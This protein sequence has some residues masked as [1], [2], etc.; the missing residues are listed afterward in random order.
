MDRRGEMPLAEGES[1]VGNF[2]AR[3]NKLELV[4]AAAN[5]A[6]ER[7]GILD[8]NYRTT[9]MN[10]MEEFRQKVDEILSGS[11]ASETTEVLSK[12]ITARG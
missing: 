12:V 8:Q 3:M 11:T 9:R 5:S 1:R 6:H 10:I 4:Q 7:I 2:D